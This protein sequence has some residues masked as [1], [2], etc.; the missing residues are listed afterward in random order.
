MTL[1]SFTAQYIVQLIP[2][3]HSNKTNKLVQMSIFENL[4]TI[5]HPVYSH[6]SKHFWWGFLQLSHL[7]IVNKL[8]VEW[9]IF[10]LKDTLLSVH[11]VLFL[12]IS[13]N[14]VWYW[15]SGLDELIEL[16][17]FS[18][19]FVELLNLFQNHLYQTEKFSCSVYPYLK[20]VT[21]CSNRCFSEMFFPP[22]GLLK[23][24]LLTQSVPDDRSYTALINL[25]IDVFVRD[26]HSKHEPSS[27]PFTATLASAQH[28]YCS[29]LF[30]LDKNR[31]NC[32]CSF[33]RGRHDWSYFR[34]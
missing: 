27:S 10:P 18:K 20:P 2:P 17:F 31:H 34:S 9:N 32:L 13:R 33:H 26:K 23:S 11:S 12:S 30:F 16:L 24:C 19:P 28:L 22:S 3:E 29:V 25:L 8:C 4:I 5:Y 1:S 7:W 14:I 6:I 21:E 15:C